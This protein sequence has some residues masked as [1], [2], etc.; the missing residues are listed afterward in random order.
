MVCNSNGN[1][2]EFYVFTYIY[3]HTSSAHF[4]LVLIPLLS[5]F[6]GRLTQRITHTTL[7]FRPN[8]IRMKLQRQAYFII[9]F[10]EKIFFSLIYPSLLS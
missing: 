3:K 1:G 9:Y 4:S 7:N 2:S 6:L 8:E 5:I 10:Q